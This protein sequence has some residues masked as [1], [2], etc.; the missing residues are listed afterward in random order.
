MARLSTENAS[1]R[2]QLQELEKAAEDDKEKAEIKFLSM[3]ESNK[4]KVHVRFAKN[5]SFEEMGSFCL[6]QIFES[7][8]KHLLLE[9]DET[10]LMSALALTA[11]NRVDYATSY[12]VPSNTFAEMIA[13][14]YS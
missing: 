6:L 5:K 3:L 1:L 7:I 9:C 12:P 2:S 10:G 13:D 4:R 8:S 11:S 14:L